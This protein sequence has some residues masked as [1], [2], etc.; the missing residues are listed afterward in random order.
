MSFRM[1][2]SCCS[3]LTFKEI[4]EVVEYNAGGNWGA[5]ASRYMLL[6]P[7]GKAWAI[8]LLLAAK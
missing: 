5:H 6:V 2:T 7:V 1:A 3:D 4:H 8:A